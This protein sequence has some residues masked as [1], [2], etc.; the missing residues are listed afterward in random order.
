MANRK[1]SELPVYNT[2]GEIIDMAVIDYSKIMH[3]VNLSE[4]DFVD[5][6]KAIDKVKESIEKYGHVLVIPYKP[7]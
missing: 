5:G 7:I 2:T 3:R 4:F 1:I 6:E